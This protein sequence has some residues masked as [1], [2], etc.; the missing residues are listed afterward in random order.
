[1]KSM[2]SEIKKA[3]T[4]KIIQKFLKETVDKILSGVKY[5][6]VATFVNQQRKTVLKNKLNVFQLGVAKQVNNLDKYAAEY[7]NPGSMTVI[8]PET[9]K[10]KKLTITG[11]A[12]AACNYN[13]LLNELEQGA[14]PVSAGD[15]ILIYYLKPNDYGFKSIGFPA[16]ISHFPKWFL[17]NFAVDISLTEDKMFDSK[18]EGIFNA[19]GEDVPSPQS[20]L[21]N[22]ILDF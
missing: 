2:G 21:T 8:N 7:M 17:E 1:M 18:L 11:Q 16:E 12:R 5:P 9:G 10:P 13:Y 14:K 3:D 20:V 6:E 4:P 19:L 22:S 15:K